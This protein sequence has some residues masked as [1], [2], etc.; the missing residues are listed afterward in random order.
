MSKHKSDNILVHGAIRCKNCEAVWNRD[1]NIEK[2]IK[3]INKI[4]I[5]FH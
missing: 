1:V 3:N 4:I 2:D 5:I